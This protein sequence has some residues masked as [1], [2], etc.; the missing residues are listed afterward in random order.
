MQSNTIEKAKEI[1][2]YMS[3][4]DSRGKSDALVICCSYDLRV[5]DHACKLI[6]SGI[7][8]KLIIS[9]KHGYWTRHLWNEPEAQVF[10]ER[11]IS[12]GINKDKILL[13]LNA[14]NFGEN[15]VFSRAL[16]PEAKTVTFVTKPNSLLRVQL[17]AKAQWPEVNAFVSA[18]S[19]NFP[20]EISNTIGLWGLINEMVGDINRIQKY[21]EKGFQIPHTLPKHVVENYRYLIAQGFTVRLIPSS[22][23]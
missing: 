15:I 2:S 7:S 3:A 23:N 18:P 5:C 13:E 21:P 4:V 14:T 16:I 12:N 9:G 22:D 6:D 20:D 17:T 8:D 10:Y 19:I 1:W 11:A